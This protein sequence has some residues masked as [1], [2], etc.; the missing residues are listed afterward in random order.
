MFKMSAA[1]SAGLVTML[2]RLNGRDGD[3]TIKTLKYVEGFARANKLNGRQ[4]FEEMA[5]HGNDLAESGNAVAEAMA[6]AAVDAKRLGYNMSSMTNLANRL[7]DDFE[8]ALQ[9]QAKLATMFPGADMSEVMYASQFGTIEDV[10]ESVKSLVQSIG[11]D[12]K[13][14]PRSFKQALSQ[15][16]GLSAT[17]LMNINGAKGDPRL[18]DDASFKQDVMTPA[19][20]IITGGLPIIIDLLKTIAFTLAGFIFGPIRKLTEWVGGM[21]GGVTPSASATV[22]GAIRHAGGMIDGSGPFKMMQLPRFHGG[23]LPN[24]IPAILQKGEAVLT[25]KMMTGLSD[26]IGGVM[27]VGDELNDA[28]SVKSAAH[29]NNMGSDSEIIALL[30]QILVATKE[31]KSV[32]MDGKKV[33]NALMN[34]YR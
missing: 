7:V 6:R 18:A 9:T 28:G 2:Y 12:F 5:K 26:V 10:T 17:E 14:M 29:A 3:Q 33:G 1:D 30:R 15:A 31:G 27:A 16:T 8:G 4:V 19:F 24:E 25:A 11:M 23:L 21:F 32:T 22:Q 34:A 20:D 13:T